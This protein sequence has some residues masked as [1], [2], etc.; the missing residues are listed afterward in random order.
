MSDVLDVYDHEVEAMLGLLADLRELA[1]SRRHN[2]GD[3][4]RMIRDRFA[5]I[6]FTVDV[7]WY[8]FEVD[9]QPQEG[10]MPEVTVTGRT[11]A[12]FQF[13]P[14]RQVHE[15]VSNV[16]GLPGEEGWIRTS[17]GPVRR[18]LDGKGKGHG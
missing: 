1:S 16:L 5:S 9:G 14:D 18:F 10:A 2:Y 8:E 6:G 11:D 7:S 13:D 4:E 15:A 17:P 3:F 12:R